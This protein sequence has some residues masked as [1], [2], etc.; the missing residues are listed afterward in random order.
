[1]NI[2]IY[3]KQLAPKGISHETFQGSLLNELPR[4]T[5]QF[6]VFVFTDDAANSNSLPVGVAHIPLRRHKLPIRLAR[7]AIRM[8]VTACLPV[9]R[10]LGYDPKHMRW[11]R[12]M[13]HPEPL[14]FEDFKRLNIRLMWF[15]NGDRTHVNMPY[16]LTVWD[17]NYRI[18]PEFP[19]WKLIPYGPA[20]QL[21]RAAFLITGTEEGARQLEVCYGVD[22]ARVR[23]IPFPTP[24]FATND[25]SADS[26]FRANLP[27]RY[28]I[29][30]ARFWPH[31]NHVT[32][33]LALAELKKRGAEYHIVFT[34]RDD[35][36]WD[37]VRRLAEKC[38]VRDCIHYLGVLSLQD[39]AFVCRHSWCMVYASLFGPDNLPPLEAF[40]MGVPVIASDIPAAREQYGDACTFFSPCSENELADA[41]ER[42]DRDSD[43][44]RELVARGRRLAALRTPAAYVDA[45]QETIAEFATLARTWEHCDDEF[46]G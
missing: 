46:F 24:H 34:G 45:V 32:V 30:P 20:P 12:H 27:S 40:A 13:L 8:L 6:N 5:E 31:K 41:I 21:D 17:I 25:V 10:R 16:I 26:P 14:C 9:L 36:N 4:L 11:I 28:M 15:M 42:M 18:H 37:Y 22:R 23:V 19:E 7:W 39:L 43:L 44:R 29:Y 3:V 33:V 1:M 38:G 2:G 35:G